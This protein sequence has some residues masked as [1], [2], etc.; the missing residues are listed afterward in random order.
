MENL[1]GC[2]DKFECHSECDGNYMGY[3]EQLNKTIRLRFVKIHFCSQVLT[4]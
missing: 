2:E 3:F 4:Y 1:I